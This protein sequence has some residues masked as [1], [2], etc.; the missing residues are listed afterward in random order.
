VRR[1][2][3]QRAKGQRLKFQSK[4]R[5]AR[6]MLAEIAPLLPDDFQVYVLFDSWYFSAKLIRYCRR[7]R[8]QAPRLGDWHTD[9][10]RT[11]PCT[12]HRYSV[13]GTAPVNA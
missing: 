11:V 7:H 3:R 10:V 2:N 9:P 6:A 8:V 13:L 12:L 1:I 4:Y 5:L